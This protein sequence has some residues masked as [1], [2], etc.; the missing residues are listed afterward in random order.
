MQ[1]GEWHSN[2]KTTPL[3]NQTHQRM[4]KFQKFILVFCAINLCSSGSTV[5]GLIQSELILHHDSNIADDSVQNFLTSIQNILLALS[6]GW[7]N[8]G[9]FPQLV[10]SFFV[11]SD[12]MPTRDQFERFIGSN[13]YF[14]PNDVIKWTTWNQHITNEDRKAFE[15]HMRRSNPDFQMFTYTRNGSKLSIP[16]NAS[17]NYSPITYCSPRSDDLVGFDVYNDPIEGAAIRT[18]STTGRTVSI[19]PFLLQG[20]PIET[21]FRIAALAPHSLSLASPRAL[22]CVGST[23]WAC[24]P[25]SHSFPTD[26]SSPPLLPAPS[27]QSPPRTTPA[28][29]RPSFT[30]TLSSAKYSAPS[31]SPAPTCSSSNPP[32]TATDKGRRGTLRTTSRRRPAVPR[33]CPRPRRKRCNQVTP[34]QACVRR[35]RLLH[36]TRRAHLASCAGCRRRARGPGVGLHPRARRAPLRPPPPRRRSRARGLAPARHRPPTVRAA[37]PQATKDIPPGSAAHAGLART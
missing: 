15:D 10:V 19:A 24:P 8:A 36:P 3:C 11:A 23:G 35:P 20:L 34:F 25:T 16:Q 7:T 29:S 12:T 31:P 4:G 21:E 6:S 17:Q 2:K 30:S 27:P 33:A 18:A 28:A 32:P 37:L 14:D 22:T 26:P 13:K 1:K 5:L 9:V